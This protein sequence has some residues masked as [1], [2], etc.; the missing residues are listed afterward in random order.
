MCKIKVVC[1]FDINI[2]VRDA[3]QHAAQMANV[4]KRGTGVV[5]KRFLEFLPIVTDLVGTIIDIAKVSI[6]LHLKL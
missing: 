3:L 1:Y 5:D 4:H 2:L 6:P